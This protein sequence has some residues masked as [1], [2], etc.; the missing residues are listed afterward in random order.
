[1]IIK[2]IINLINYFY[3]IIQLKMEEAKYIEGKE[4][5]N[6]PKAIPIEVMMKLGELTKT[7]ICKINSNGKKGT[8][9]FLKTPFGFFN[10]LNALITS[11]QVLNKDDIQPGQ[12]INFTLNNDSKE[13][14]ILIDDTRKTYTN[15]SYDF[16]S[17]EI[18][19]DDN[20]DEKYFF[21]IDKRMFQENENVNA[22][23]I[24]AN[25]QIFLL[26]YPKAIQTEVSVGIIQLIKEDNL[27][28]HHTCDTTNG[29]SGGP[30]INRDNFEVIGIH[31]GASE[32]GKNYNIGILLKE[33]IEKFYEEI[34]IKKNNK[35]NKN[36][37][38]NKSIYIKENLINDDE[39]IDEIIIGYKIDNIE[40]SENIKIFGDDFVKNNKNKCK[41]ILNGNEFEL[42][43]N[44]NVNI[45]Q[46]KNNIFEIKLKGIKNVT[47]FSYMFCSCESLSILPDISKLNTQ[48]VTNMSYMLSGCESLSSLPDISKWNTQNVTNMSS[49]FSG[50]KLLSSLPDISKWNTQ[51]VTNMSS[52]FYNCY[53]LRS[54]PNISRWNTQNVERMDEMFNF[55][56]SFLSLSDISEWNT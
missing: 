38:I 11:N 12:T 31:V 48:N 41:I 50:C 56:G 14:N 5:E 36:K 22:S 46:L 8:G 45:N 18:K 21:D 16:T 23:Q 2:L 35:D 33:P 4:L 44:I 26:H 47:N 10:T 20:I 7:H 27:T 13:Y 29:S 55:C 54:L 52:M 25:S 51:N 1:M 28:I 9:F 30:I 19:K 49:M 40:Y 32:G 37:D 39:N 42:S 43:E 24:F 3:Y 15:E 17:I 6:Q 34:K 53:L